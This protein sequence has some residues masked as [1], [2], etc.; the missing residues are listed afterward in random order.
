MPTR[1][2][3]QDSVLHEARELV[4]SAQRELLITSPWIRQR[5]ASAL[6]RDEQHPVQV[7][8]SSLRGLSEQIWI[9]FSKTR[10]QIQQVWVVWL[11]AQASEDSIE[12]ISRFPSQSIKPCEHA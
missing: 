11:Q 10:L 1:I 12:G 4:K 5:S 6:L 9:L 7:D 3:N 8:R 2:V